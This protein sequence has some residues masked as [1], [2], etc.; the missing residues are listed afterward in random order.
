MPNTLYILGHSHILEYYKT[1][2]GFLNYVGYN[3]E[4]Y[5][6]VQGSTSALMFVGNYVY[7][8][9]SHNRNEADEQVPSGT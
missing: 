1:L 7:V 5:A 3:M 9:D 2:S 4:Q 6:T 8:F